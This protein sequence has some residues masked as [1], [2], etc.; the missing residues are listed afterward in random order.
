MSKRKSNSPVPTEGKLYKSTLK[1][2]IPW[3]L[4]GY[5]SA[6]VLVREGL[7]GLKMYPVESEDPF[8]YI[9]GYAPL[10]VSSLIF[11]G[12]TAL[13]LLN[14]NRRIGISDRFFLYRQGTGKTTKFPWSKIS[15]QTPF[16]NK[17]GMFSRAS[18]TDGNKTITIEKF[19]FP[20]FLEICHELKDARNQ[21]RNREAENETTSRGNDD[22]KS[23]LGMR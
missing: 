6:G 16:S 23:S 1:K 8:R 7:L 19:F 20:D 13:L 9:S 18:V 15:I 3:A 10:V 5:A 21:A 22:L 11:I 12:I 14:A 4:A 17:P 2:L